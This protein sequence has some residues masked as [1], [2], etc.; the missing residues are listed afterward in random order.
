[1]KIRKKALGLFWTVL[2]RYMVLSV[3]SLALGAAAGMALMQWRIAPEMVELARQRDAARQELH[4]AQTEAAPLQARIARLERENEAYADQING[5]YERLAALEAAGDATAPDT[6]ALWGM[7]EE[8]WTDE[9]EERPA[10]RRPP[11]ADRRDASE[12]ENATQD[13]ERW[14]ELRQRRE[15]FATRFYER[16][17]G[18]L[19]NALAQTNDPASQER[20]YAMSEYARYM[21]DLRQEQMRA[22]TEEQREALREEM[23]T[24]AREIARL[25]EDQQ[26]Q[27]LRDVATNFGITDRSSQ[28]KFYNAMQRTLQSPFFQP[29]GGMAAGGRMGGGP[30][31]EA[32]NRPPRLLVTALWAPSAVC[33]GERCWDL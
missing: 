15:E 16:V 18:F 30:P 21:H 9:E 32:G 33:Q 6:A 5:L 4:Q 10:R 8:A 13:E 28:R 7:L 24:A 29:G 1:M 26:R 31:A 27:M 2:M 20:L 23:R 25:V 22:E 14:R 17:D 11:W 12:G 3:V 19:N